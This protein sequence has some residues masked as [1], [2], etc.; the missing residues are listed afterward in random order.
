MKRAGRGGDACG[1]GAGPTP[2]RSRLAG[3]AHSLP[4][5]C[6]QPLWSTALPTTTPTTLTALVHVLE[7]DAVVAAT[8]AGDLFSL[9]S[10]NGAAEE[11]GAVGGGVAALAWS[12]T[13]DAVALISG[14]GRLLLM[15]RSWTVCADVAVFQ[16]WA[17]PV[18]AR[19][20]P[21]DDSDEAAG[22]PP[23]SAGWAALGPDDAGLSWRADGRALVTTS[24]RRQDEEEEDRPPAVACTLRTWDVGGPAGLALHALGEAVPGLASPVTWQPN[25]RHIYGVVNGGPGGGDGGDGSRVVL[26]ERNGLTHGGFGLVS[27]AGDGGGGGGAPPPNVSSIAWSPDSEVLAIGLAGGPPSVQLWRRANWHWYLKREVRLLPPPDPNPGGGGGGGGAAAASPPRPC[28]AWDEAAPL[29]LRIAHG[30]GSLRALDFG[31]DVSVSSAGTAAVVDST[32]VLLT[33]L[34]LSTPPPPLCSL[35]VACPAPVSC[36]AI[37]PVKPDDDGEDDGD[38]ETLVAALADGRLVL[39]AAPVWDEWEGCLEEDGPSLPPPPFAPSDPAG[40]YE[41]ERI[42]ATT[43]TVSPP[44][45][46]GGAAVRDLAWLAPGRLLVG[47]SG[48]GRGGL[49]GACVELEVKGAAATVLST[50]PCPPIVRLAQVPRTAE[51]GDA[52]GALVQASSGAVS[53]WRA[54]GVPADLAPFPSPCPTLRALPAT[55]P[56]PVGLTGRGDLY[57]GAR[58]VAVSINSVAIR[59]A[60]PGGPFLLYTSVDAVLKTLPASAA[61]D[62]A[63]PLDGPGLRPG[64][65]APARAAPG[66]ARRFAAREGDLQVYM[67]KAMKGRGLATTSGADVTE[68]AVE[69][70]AALV[71]A[72]PGPSCLVVLQMPRGNLETIAPRALVLTAVATALVAGDYAP[73]AAA[74]AAHRLDPNLLVDVGWPS[75]LTGAPAFVAAVV[76]DAAISDLLRALKPASTVSPGGLYAWVARIPGAA[77]SEAAEGGTTDKVAAVA[78]ALRAALMAAGPARYLRPLLTSHAILGDLGSALALVKAR[79]EAEL[80]AGCDI[81]ASAAPA[82]PALPPPSGEALGTAR[83]RAAAV[84][85][86]ARPPTADAG[87][88]HLLLSVPFETLYAAALASYDLGLA[89]LVALAAG[90]DPAEHLVDLRAWAALP[91]GPLRRHAIDAHL[92]R[93]DRA[94]AALV[95]AG[96]AHAD[97]ALDL[98][99]K[100]GL[101]REAVGL[102]DAAACLPAWADPASLASAR[103]T[104]L[105]RYAADLSAKGKPEDAAVALMAA[106]DLEGAVDAYR[107]AGQATPA[108]ALAARAGWPRARLRTLASDLADSLAAVGRFAAAASVASRH[109][110]DPDSAVAWLARAHEWRAALGEA[111]AAGRDDLVETVLAPAAAEAA[112]AALAD[113][114]E[115]AG[116]VAKYLGRYQGVQARREALDVAIGPDGAASARARGGGGGGSCESDTGAVAADE[117]GSDAGSGWGSNLSALSA[118]T[119]TSTVAGGLAPSSAASTAPP[120]TTGGRPALRGGNGGGGGAKKKKKPS[121]AARRLRAGGAAEEAGLAELLTSLAPSAATLTSTGELAELLILLGHE[122]D[123]RL[124]QAALADLVAAAAAAAEHLAAHPPRVTPPNAGAPPPPPPAAPPGP[125]WK[126]DLLRS[127]KLAGREGGEEETAAAREE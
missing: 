101:L 75:F 66:S 125:R 42:G 80:V 95:D 98:A 53:W 8:A 59:P 12:P 23:G 68:R 15:D 70:G 16:A 39:A 46:A 44:D 38:C 7:L 61:L 99:A 111:Y 87:L 104:A 20:L 103:S 25:S 114:R 14:A 71:A 51:T 110:D 29:R 73:A 119:T 113:A 90:R 102:L 126:W 94:L 118:Y 77:G 54:G 30:A 45:W 60:G 56:I 105:A 35:A 112:A 93:H 67:H 47:L 11:V 41:H 115:V 43:L 74:V 124:L 33:P 109:L 52:P 65:A 26:F 27:A 28:L 55:P 106:G 3:A 120:S 48:G 127:V 9:A 58:H 96:P 22:A 1:R 57:C 88:R 31:L 122:D 4:L 18:P 108:L 17:T 91:A 24:R 2:T 76:D 85:G 34:A 10:A 83:R 62:P 100:R 79:R 86:T 78:R 89:Y 6:T 117:G 116:R 72:P 97:G 49:N 81:E 69:E 123:A 19:T 36:V 21:R 13:G 121:K 37:S 92:G 32:H 5:P 64:P 40:E 82:P 63:T 50:R 107:A 84:T